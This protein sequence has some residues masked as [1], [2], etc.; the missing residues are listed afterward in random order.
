[1]RTRTQVGERRSRRRPW[2]TRRQSGAAVAGVMLLVIV[3][4][5]CEPPPE[6][7]IIVRHSATAPNWG[8]GGDPF[9]MREG[10]TYFVFGSNTNMRLPITTVTDLAT[11]YTENSFVA[12]SV[13]GMPS[14]PAWATDE[15][16]WAPTVVHAPG[17]YVLWFAANR[18]NPPDPANRQCIGRAFAFSPAGPYIPEASPF[19]CG[20]DGIHGA[21]DP[22]VFVEPGGA[23][24]L[25]AAFG[26]TSQPIRVIPLDQYGD[27]ANRRPDGQ[28]EP[29]PYPVLAVNHGWEGRFIENPSMVYDPSTDTYL[30][31]YSA[32]DW[33]TAGYSTGLARC[34]TP[35]GLCATNE[36]GPWLASSSTRTGPGGL[37]F[38]TA[39]DGTPMAVYASFAAGQEGADR[40]RFFTTATIGLGNQPTI[41]PYALRRGRH[42]K[43]GP[44]LSA[45][46]LAPT[47]QA[48]RRFVVIE[49][50]EWFRLALADRDDR[51]V[52]LAPI[53]EFVHHRLGPAGGEIEVVVVGSLGGRVTFDGDARS[54]G[55]PESIEQ[56]AGEVQS[57][58]AN[59]G[60]VGESGVRAIDVVDHHSD[61]VLRSNLWVYSVLVDAASVPVAREIAPPGRFVIAAGSACAVATDPTGAHV[62]GQ[63]I[64]ERRVRAG[65][66]GDGAAHPTRHGLAGPL[67]LVA[68][69]PGPIPRPDA[70][71]SSAISAAAFVVEAP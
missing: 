21:L 48:S 19:N 15:V 34:S 68:H 10:S 9:V 44:P 1:M 67:H 12:A 52:V 35:V 26:D 69:P 45:E 66:G 64:S 41:T 2:R 37:S 32:G 55:C 62:F 13:E 14:K 6:L 16:L 7:G 70:A 36:A 59:R 24:W 54:A 50:D 42:R 39:A 3:A 65:E 61:H 5:A 30:M 49:A 57:D 28:A 38:F 17:R 47:I 58:P 40:A 31:S 33:Y 20:T 27:P 60:R 8:R 23:M 22:N 29:W 53:D 51:R 46:D 4:G 63:V 56:P 18:Y 11:T 43:R 25:Y 71:F